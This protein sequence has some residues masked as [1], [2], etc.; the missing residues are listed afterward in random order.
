MYLDYAENFRFRFERLIVSKGFDVLLTVH[1]S[2]FILVIIQ[3]L[4]IKLYNY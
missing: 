2:I 1:L 3:I 4:C